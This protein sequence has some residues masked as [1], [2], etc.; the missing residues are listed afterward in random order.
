MVINGSGLIFF[1]GLLRLE[2]R[3][4][5]SAI[6]GLGDC[7]LACPGDHDL[8]SGDNKGPP[9][10]ASACCSLWSEFSVPQSSANLATLN[11]KSYTLNPR[12][13]TLKPKLCCQKRI[14]VVPARRC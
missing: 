14:E 9:D 4:E 13:S 7:S 8:I 3:T 2:R 1:F 11:H 10:L 5:G 12:P 6:S